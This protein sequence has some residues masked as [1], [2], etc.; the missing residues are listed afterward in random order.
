MTLKETQ[1]RDGEQWSRGHNL[2]SGVA[3]N[4]SLDEEVR[5]GLVHRLGL[6]VVLLTKA[7]L[8]QGQEGIGEVLENYYYLPEE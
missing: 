7:G 4:Q 1:R 3:V 8:H 6:H 2:V 5:D